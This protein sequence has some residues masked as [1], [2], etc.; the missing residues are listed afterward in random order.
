[1]LALNTQLLPVHLKAGLGTFWE[2]TDTG[3]L[4][5]LLGGFG[6]PLVMGLLK[7]TL[8]FHL[9]LS[10]LHQMFPH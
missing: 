4:Q 9:P 10:K 3:L 1:M 7:L 6:Q 2:K 5:E 8:T